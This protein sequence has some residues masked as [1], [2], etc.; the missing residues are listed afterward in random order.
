M[1]ELV[2]VHPGTVHVQRA[3]DVVQIRREVVLFVAHDRLIRTSVP[4]SDIG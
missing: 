1:G 2:G 4:L 3:A